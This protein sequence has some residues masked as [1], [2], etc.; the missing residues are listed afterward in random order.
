MN[1]NYNIGSAIKNVLQECIDKKMPVKTSY[2]IM[3][4]IKA[5]EEE[6]VFFASKMQEIIN[7][8]GEKDENGNYIQTGENSIKI[9]DGKIE[10]CNAKINELNS[11]EIKIPDYKI[12]LEELEL[13]EL[14]PKELYLLDSIIE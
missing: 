6:E 11:I 14:S 3:K 7:E 1:I 13:I 4:I 8:Y 12:S 2:K 10:E 9:K 5:I